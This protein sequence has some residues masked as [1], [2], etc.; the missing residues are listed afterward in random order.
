MQFVKHPFSQFEDDVPIW[1]DGQL[2][3]W[4]VY[5][6][7]SLPLGVKFWPRGELCTL[8]EL[9]ITFFILRGEDSLMLRRTK[10]QTEGIH[11]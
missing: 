3:L 10:G 9:C 2:L 8:G 5:S 1:E 6:N 7:M 11:P 4:P